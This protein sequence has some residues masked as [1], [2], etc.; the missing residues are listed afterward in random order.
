MRRFDLQLFT[1]DQE[2]VKEKVKEEVKEEVKE[3]I[4]LTQEELDAKIQAE[5]DRRV[6]KALET[7]KVKLEAE[8]SEKIKKERQEAEEL[9]K[10]SEKERAEKERQKEREQFEQER[11]LFQKEKLELQTVKILSERNIPSEFASFVIAESNEE[12]LERINQMEEL[13]NKAIESAVNARL[14]G[15][16]PKNATTQSE[17]VT[18]AD[19]NRMS[20]RERV[21]FKNNHPDKF[22]ELMK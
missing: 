17:G 8:L 7:Q 5:A 2:K 11:K 3:A 12:T 15:K 10:L 1:D 6:T 13:F 19:Y 9:A 22:N 18:L 4:Q 14:K 21:E 20:Y 16:T